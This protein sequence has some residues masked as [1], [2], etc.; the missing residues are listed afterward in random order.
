MKIH[1]IDPADYSP[2]S[3][4]WTIA[5]DVILSEGENPA[6]IDK[7][8]TA[9][10]EDRELIWEV[11]IIDEPRIENGEIVHPVEEVTIAGNLGDM[12]EQIDRIGSE[13]VWRGRTAAPPVRISQMTV[14]GE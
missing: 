4:E 2:D 7:V 8:L 6:K 10:T 1:D 13:L 11:Q 5:D 14:A 3:A 9:E 12:F